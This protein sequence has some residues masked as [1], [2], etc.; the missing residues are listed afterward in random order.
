MRTWSSVES[1]TEKRKKNLFGSVV[2]CKQ[3]NEQKLIRFMFCVISKPLDKHVV[4]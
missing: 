1:D 4:Y 3:E 2:D